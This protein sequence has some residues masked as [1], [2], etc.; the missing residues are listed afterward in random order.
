MVERRGIAIVAGVLTM[1]LGTLCSQGHAAVQATIDS[2]VTSY[3]RGS[4]QAIGFTLNGPLPAGGQVL[5]IAWSDSQ[6]S[7]VGGFSPV[8]KQSPWKIPSTELDKLPTGRVDLQILV[9]DGSGVLSQSDQW[10][11]VTDPLPPLS[12]SFPSDA[13]ASYQQGSG[14]SV[15]FVVTGAMPS[16]GDVL[17]LAWS[18]SQARM[19]GSFAFAKTQSPWE[20]PAAKMDS[21]PAG[22]VQLQL[23]LRVNNQVMMQAT[24]WVT[25]NA[26]VG[27]TTV[28]F[29]SNA[30][31]T[32]TIGS[33][34]SIGFNV[35]GPLPSGG[36]VLVMAWSDAQRS[37]VS[38]FVHEVKSSPWTIPSS[39]LD[40]L[41]AGGVEL[42]LLLRSS[43]G[44]IYSVRQIAKHT[45][46]VSS[47][48]GGNPQ[49]P[50]SSLQID[51]LTG[52]HNGDTVTG[53]LNVSANISGGVPNRVVYTLF[54]GST[55]VATSTATSSPYT[56]SWDSSTSA[57]GTYTLYVDAYADS[58]NK[59]TDEL[60]IQFSVKAPTPPQ[61][62]ITTSETGWTKFTASSDTR[63]IYVSS[64]QGS[65][66]NSGLSQDAPVQTA[67]K[68]YSLLRNGHADWLLFR[69]G[70]TFQGGLPYL[71]KSGA[72]KA[73]PELI[74]AY[75]DLAQPR[76]YFK[77]TD[78]FINIWGG[79]PSHIA[80]VGLH[81]SQYDRNP[82]DPGY[83]PNATGAEGIRWLTA[84][85]DVLIENCLV[86]W[87]Q[88]GIDIQQGSDYRLRR[89]VIRDCYSNNSNDASG[90]FIGPVDQLL[91]EGNIYDH[92]GYLPFVGNGRSVRDHDLYTYNCTNVTVKNNIFANASSMGYKCK[93]EGSAAA[94]HDI[95]ITG[96]LFAGDGI[97]LTF[98]QNG[99]IPYS[100]QNI[101]VS[102]NAFA[103]IGGNMILESGDIANEGLG[104][105]TKSIANATFDGNVFVNSTNAGSRI[106][107]AIK[108]SDW[109][110][111]K[112]IT[113]TNNI[114]SPTFQ[115]TVGPF[116]SNMSAT[117]MS[118]NVVMSN[119]SGYVDAARSVASYD[120][121]IGGSGTLDA[122]MNEAEK[123]KKGNWRPA[124]TPAAVISYLQAGM[125]G[126]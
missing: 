67:A 74:G 11:N 109:R 72:S 6:M 65:D 84:S 34:Q 95:A 83:N 12:V 68:G 37:M 96:N 14:T 47:G 52:L 38:S 73:N 75:G 49:P 106:V 126:K 122:F 40:T 108:V 50:T 1:L 100:V 121:S 28:S 61:P 32:Y 57:A 24:H 15:P 5:V 8:I 22:R 58:S 80:I 77:C 105:D 3:V 115:Y 46:T 79:A 120:S 60:P 31:A 124:F 29:A 98:G 4:G 16:N 81:I 82:N 123:Q 48:G 92:N 20:I 45:M 9:Q 117:T 103:Q 17:V 102:H 104:V 76:P 26:P 23:L 110:P 7:M 62:P 89:N 63:V 51:S 39:W 93:G 55:Q 88:M 53:L 25:V 64:S 99:E 59:V 18:D 10:I 69:R 43:S 54:Q 19:V 71:T 35:S 44:G 85:S 107:W 87:F 90:S 42:Q 101:N 41:P 114:A 21:L 118:G 116:I 112:N 119:G 30:P 94:S 86:E 70:D 36:D 97:G 113:I 56:F 78:S 66:S 125:A 27:P 91:V 2:S 13:V 33:G 111:Q